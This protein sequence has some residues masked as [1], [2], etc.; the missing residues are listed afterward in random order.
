MKIQIFSTLITHR[1]RQCNCIA[2]YHNELLS[3]FVNTL[4]TNIVSFVGG[5]ETAQG[6]VKIYMFH[7]D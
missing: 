6:Q 2:L 1:A 4:E 5:F 7:V 3:S